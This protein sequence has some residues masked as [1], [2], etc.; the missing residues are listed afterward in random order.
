MGVTGEITSSSCKSPVKLC[1]RREIVFTSSI[2]TLRYPCSL[3]LVIFRDEGD[4]FGAEEQGYMIGCNIS[5]IPWQFDLD[6]KNYSRV[7]VSWQSISISKCIQAN[8][9]F[10]H[11]YAGR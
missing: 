10:K 1:V 8:G 6:R 7:F 9:F 4:C 5:L 2:D 3:I 11:N